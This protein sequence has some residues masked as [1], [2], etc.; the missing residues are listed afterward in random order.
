LS[1]YRRWFAKRVTWLGADEIPSL[2]VILQ[3][4]GGI[5]IFAGDAGMSR[6][7]SIKAA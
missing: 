1:A 5:A 2:S 4:S 7:D 6:E 3:P